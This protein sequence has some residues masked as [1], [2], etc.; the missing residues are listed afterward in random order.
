MELVYKISTTYSPDPM[1]FM[2]QM[3]NVLNCFSL[4]SIVVQLKPNYNSKMA[5]QVEKMTNTSTVNTF[6]GFLPLTPFSPLTKSKPPKVK[7]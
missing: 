6:D 2:P 4:A 3:L 7:S 5:S 1:I